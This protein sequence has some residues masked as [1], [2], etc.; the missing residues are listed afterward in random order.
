MQSLEHR[1][2]AQT[3][4]AQFKE[5]QQSMA[6]FHP[7]HLHSGHNPDFGLPRVTLRLVTGVGG[8]D[9][10]KPLRWNRG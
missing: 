2:L 4:R 9:R 7:S 8:T 6:R 5:G 1:A 10:T 3:A